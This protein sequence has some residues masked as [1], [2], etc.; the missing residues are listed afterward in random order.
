MTLPYAREKA[1]LLLLFFALDFRGP[2]SRTLH[3]P[4]AQRQSEPQA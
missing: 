1:A 3:S 2:R 4:A